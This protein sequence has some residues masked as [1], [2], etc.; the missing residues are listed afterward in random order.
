M[1]REMGINIKKYF[2]A[3]GWRLVYKKLNI[4]DSSKDFCEIWIILF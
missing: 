1:G 4:G 3:L 2:I